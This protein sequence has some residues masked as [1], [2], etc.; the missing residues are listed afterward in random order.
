MFLNYIKQ[1]KTH[2]CIVHC[3]W[4]SKYRNIFDFIYNSVFIPVINKKYVWQHD[5]DYVNGYIY[6]HKDNLSHSTVPVTPQS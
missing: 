3:P 4:L 1:T 2:P 5:C 6:F